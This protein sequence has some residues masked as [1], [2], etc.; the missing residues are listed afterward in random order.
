RKG[1]QKAHAIITTKSRE[2]ANRI[3]KDG[4]AIAGNRYR[5][6]KLEDDPRRCYKCQTIEP[7]HRA[8]DCPNDEVCA[9]CYSKKHVAGTCDRDARHYA[10][11][12]CIAAKKPYNH[13]SW[14]RQCP[15]FLAKR[16]KLRD[17]F[18]ENHFRYYPITDVEWTWTRKAES[19]EEEMYAERWNGNYD[20]NRHEDTRN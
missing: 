10:C 17:R 15:I 14:S 4:I 1:Q 13:A 11:A 5:A 20:R 7:G 6:R 3:I 18:P 16:S 19:I 2:T 9:N 12:S 8:A